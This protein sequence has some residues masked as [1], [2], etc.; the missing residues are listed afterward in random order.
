MILQERRKIPLELLENDNPT[1]FGHCEVDDLIS[2]LSTNGQLS[3]IR[4]R[5]HPT[6]QDKFQIIF[7]SRRVAAA[8]KLGWNT[9][10]A[11][12]APATDAEALVL[13]FCEN[14]DRKDFT[15]LEKALIIKGLHDLTGKPYAEVAKILGKSA[16]FIS[17]HSAMLKLF[18]ETI[19]TKEERFRI[20]SA[21]TEMHARVLSKIENQNE[22]WN[23]A[24]LVIA[25]G[26]SARELLKVYVRRS[27][28]A[29]KRHARR[30]SDEKEIRE[31]IYETINGMNLRDVQ[32]CTKRFSRDFTLLDDFPPYQKLGAEEA[33]DH[34]LNVLRSVDDFHQIIED[35]HLKLREKFAYA[36]VFTLYELSSGG[37]TISTRSR[38]TLVFEKEDFWKITHQHWSTL[39]P[40]LLLNFPFRKTQVSHGGGTD[41]KLDH[42]KTHSEYFLDSPAR[43]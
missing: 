12:V 35:V 13:A 25:S 21:L 11:V 14:S 32:L 4:V 3:P 8:R 24:K 23:T 6:N 1:R 42:F 38:G 30:I 43:A 40:A 5:P 15:D 29:G 2:S 34:F 28:D 7:G 19:G 10:D 37:K 20:L 17:Q 16:S 22:R 9:I 39:D 33:K 36:I 27:E 26:M 31:L 18:P 41:R